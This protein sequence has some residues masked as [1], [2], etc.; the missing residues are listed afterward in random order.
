[1]PWGLTRFK[2]E[3]VLTSYVPGIAAVALAAALG[4]VGLMLIGR[5]ASKPQTAD[6]AP[7]EIAA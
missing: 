4:W 2:A 6:D 5:S 7:A 3:V 1:M